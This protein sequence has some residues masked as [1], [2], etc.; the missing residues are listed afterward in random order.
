MN[1]E[2]CPSETETGAFINFFPEEMPSAVLKQQVREWMAE[3]EFNFDDEDEYL[4]FQLGSSFA[5]VFFY[6]MPLASCAVRCLS[7]QAYALGRY[8]AQ[9]LDD[10]D[11]S[12][13]NQQLEVGRLVRG[14]KRQVLFVYNVLA[15]GVK[16]AA[17]FNMLDTFRNGIDT[18][19]RQIQTLLATT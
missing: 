4:A 8:G 14:H 13:I 5:A 19:E 11:L 16:K 3:R 18:T 6:Q 15:E 1:M 17:F 2:Q 10:D 9:F 7:F 12:A